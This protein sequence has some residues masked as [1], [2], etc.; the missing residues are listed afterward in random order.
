MNFDLDAAIASE[1]AGNAA[2]AAA[3]AAN[4]AGT[5]LDASIALL[6]MVSDLH[7][8]FSEMRNWETKRFNDVIDGLNNRK[9]ENEALMTEIENLKEQVAGLQSRL[10]QEEKKNKGFAR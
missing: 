9:H 2:Y 3:R 7:D 6:K 5:N 4:A 1:K 10:Y 8:R